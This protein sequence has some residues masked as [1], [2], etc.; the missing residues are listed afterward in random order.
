M[1]RIAAGG[2]PALEGGTLPRACCVLG[3]TI[4]FSCEYPHLDL[5]SFHQKRRKHHPEQMMT[6]ET[7][8]LAV[9]CYKS[10]AAA[11]CWARGLQGLPPDHVCVRQ[12]LSSPSSPNSD[13]DDLGVSAR[14]R[15]GWKTTENLGVGGPSRSQQRSEHGI[16][17]VWCFDNCSS[18]G[19]GP[20]R[21]RW[22]NFLASGVPGPRIT[23]RN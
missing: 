22:S 2:A 8:S 18:L 12:S 9:V 6:V 20:W 7:V 3:R 14:I 17:S 21:W 15:K 13:L 23:C 19:F 11:P 1:L 5:V 10:S 16:L 4:R